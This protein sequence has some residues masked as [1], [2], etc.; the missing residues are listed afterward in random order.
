MHQPFAIF[1]ANMYFPQAHTLAYS[2]NLIGSAMFAAPVV[3]LTGNLALGL[4]VVA[5]LSVVLCGTG[6]YVLARRLGVRPAFAIIAGLV[7]AFSPPRF[8]RLGQAHLTVVQWIPFGLAF[9]HAYL[10]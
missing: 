6:T 4:N 3:W 1:D 10:R 9:L 8:F 7:F 5:L 2:E